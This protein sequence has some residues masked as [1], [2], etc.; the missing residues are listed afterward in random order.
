MGYRGDIAID[1][2]TVALN[3]CKVGEY[4]TSFKTSPS[5][6]CYNINEKCFSKILNRYI[7]SHLKFTHIKKLMF[8]E[9]RHYVFINTDCLLHGVDHFSVCYFHVTFIISNECISHV[10]ASCDFEQDLCGWQNDNFDDFDWSRMKG[11]TATPNTG[12][13]ADHTSSTGEPPR[14]NHQ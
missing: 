11:S 12:P 10:D 3:E 5:Q 4:S 13:R 6:L 8:R 14:K 2:V 9:A 7:I 1:D